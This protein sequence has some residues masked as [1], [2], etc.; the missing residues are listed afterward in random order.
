M[1]A[2]NLTYCPSIGIIKNAPANLIGFVSNLKTIISERNIKDENV[3]ICEIIA[4]N[5]INISSCV[6][7]I[8][9][10]GWKAQTDEFIRI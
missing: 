9:D 7:V 4:R 10:S 6:V 2:H 8:A 1:H 5:L 3:S